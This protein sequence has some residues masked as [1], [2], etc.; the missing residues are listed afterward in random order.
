MYKYLLV[1]LAIIIFSG[2]ESDT[3]G[4][5]MPEGPIMPL[6]VGNTW[7]YKT[8]SLNNDGST[9]S[10]YYD[11]IA[12]KGVTIVNGDSIFYFDHGTAGLLSGTSYSIA[13]FGDNNFK[14]FAKYPTRPGEIFR[15]D[16][17]TFVEYDTSG[18][19]LEKDTS[20]ITFV[21][22]EIPSIIT[23]PAGTYTAVHY[24]YDILNKNFSN[25]GVYYYA[26]GVG[27]VYSYYYIWNNGLVPSS[28]RELVSVDLK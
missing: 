24:Q 18:S 11:T 3:T 15:R 12:I 7:I 10:I 20:H 1:Y 26:P 21:T 16:T 23:V 19:V 5:S 9:D 2:C 4:P 14:L 13:I 27:E 28:K 22:K 17:L 8:S 6:A 25:R